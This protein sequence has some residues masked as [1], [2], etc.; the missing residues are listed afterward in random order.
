MQYIVTKDH[1]SEFPEPITF[2]KGTKLI[3]GEKYEGDEGWENWYFCSVSGQKSGFV[4]AQFI[5][6]ID[7]E[8]GIALKDYTAHELSVKEGETVSGT[9][10]LNSWLWS[11][12][13]LNGECGWVPLEHLKPKG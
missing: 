6:W 10:R 12:R 11:T 2:S 9:E 8:N 4:P 3:I 7:D 1:I 13:D 5:E